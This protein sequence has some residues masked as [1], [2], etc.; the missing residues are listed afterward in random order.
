MSIYAA[1]ALYRMLRY[2]H[3]EYYYY[4]LWP[5]YV[6]WQA[7]YI[8]ILWILLLLLLVSSPHDLPSAIHLSMA[9]KLA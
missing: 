4:Y 7:I 2:L 3:E 6:I 9:G 1:Y 8:F 5:P